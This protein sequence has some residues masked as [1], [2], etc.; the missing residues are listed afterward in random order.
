MTA[1]DWALFTPKGLLISLT[2]DVI[3]IHKPFPAA[4]GSA[5]GV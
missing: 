1:V 3:E 2:D 5:K 4:G